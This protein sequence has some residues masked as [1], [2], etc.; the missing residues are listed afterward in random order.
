MQAYNTLVKGHG[1][2]ANST[3]ADLGASVGNV[4][5]WTLEGVDRDYRCQC[6]I[7]VVAYLIIITIVF[8]CK[9]HDALK[10]EPV[11]KLDVA[12]RPNALPQNVSLCSFVLKPIRRPCLASYS[13]LLASSS[14]PRSLFLLL[15]TQR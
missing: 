12:Q 4:F 8:R 3:G 9:R 5:K 15:S 13:P 6:C 7:R 10:V 14:L 2:C 11:V 1:M